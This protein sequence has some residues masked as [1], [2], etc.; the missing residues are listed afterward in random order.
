M[1]PLVKHYHDSLRIRI[2]GNRSD[3]SS[4]DVA[5]RD[6]THIRKKRPLVLNTIG[7]PKLAVLPDPV[8]PPVVGLPTISP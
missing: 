1:G 7:K 8:V 3:L 4:M 2:R 5:G 6:V